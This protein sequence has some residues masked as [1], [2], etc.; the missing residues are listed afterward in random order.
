MMGRY[1][2]KYIVDGRSIV[3]ATAAHAKPVTSVRVCECARGRR[4]TSNPS[5]VATLT[6]TGSITLWEGRKWTVFKK[7]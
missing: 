4:P 6:C 1:Y 2:E 5:C 3:R 7:T